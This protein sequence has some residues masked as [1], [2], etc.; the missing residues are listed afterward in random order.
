MNNRPE[1]HMFVN[2]SLLFGEKFRERTY[3]VA[4]WAKR[5]M[6]NAARPVFGELLATRL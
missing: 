5:E 4:V 2:L 1:A 6:T 3:R